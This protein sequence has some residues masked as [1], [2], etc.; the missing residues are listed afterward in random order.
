MQLRSWEL[1][2]PSARVK[3]RLLSPRRPQPDSLIWSFQWLA[4]VAACLVFA[5]MILHQNF[6]GSNGLIRPEPALT[7][8][9]SNQSSLIPMENPSSPAPS[10]ASRSRFEWTNHSAFTSSVT[11]FLPGKEN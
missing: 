6:Q 9:L 10:N 3:R 5:A 8:V 1:R 11:S 7:L 2:Q 4:P